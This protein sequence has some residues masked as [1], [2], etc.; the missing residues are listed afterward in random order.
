MQRKAEDFA[1]ELGHEDNFKG[2]NGWLESFKNRHGIIFRKLCG[3]RASVPESVCEDWIK[4]IPDLV[5][6]Y[7]PK[8][9]FNADETGLFYQ[10]LPDKTAM[11]KDEA[12][13]G[14]K[15]SKARLTLLLAANEAGT[16]KL[17]PLMIGRSEKPRCFS[18]VKSFPFPYKANKISWMTSEIFG[19]WLKS[20]DK[21][22]RLK[23]RKIILFIDNCSAH[24]NLPEL[25]NVC[26]KYFP[27]NTTSKLQPMDQG[28][29]RSFKVNY[30]KQLIRKLVDA[31]DEGSTLPKINVL[32][33]IRMTD[34]AWRNVTQKT[35]QNGF[36]KAG[37]KNERE[38]EMGIIEE[39]TEISE[40]EAEETYIPDEEMIEIN[41][42]DWNAIK[43][44]LKVNIS[45]EEFLQVDDSLATCGTLTDSEIVDN[46][47]CISED[48]N[49]VDEEHIE[50]PKVTVKEAEK[51][52]ER[53][54]NFLECQENVGHEGF[55]ALSNIRKIIES[56]KIRRQKSLKDYL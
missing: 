12:C 27:A 28:V 38:E 35:I 6:G 2:S 53:L 8:N 33:S 10:C 54:T 1:K 48:E 17:P 44:G 51:A 3:E 32:D 23:K 18:K 24:N 4:N 46:V 9:I 41:S 25:K 49:E 40:K 7:E 14:G 5:K 19:N 26:V 50:A 39:E 13:R 16:E 30:R 55:A 42:Q 11:F 43:S 31:I 52:V 34:H 37:F 56:K 45:F 15:Q 20:L 29:I 21:S 22:M 36:K 47:R